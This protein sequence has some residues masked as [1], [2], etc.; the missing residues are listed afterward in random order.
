MESCELEF[1]GINR[2]HLGMYFEELGGKSQTETFPFV[3]KGDGWIGEIFREDEL[4][5]TK[6]FKV[7]AVHIRFTAE[8]ESKLE[9]LIKLYRHKTT[10]V[11]G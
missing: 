9:E 5:F 1:R 10:R 2:K 7:N 6:V 11:G 3:Y 8:S 4:E